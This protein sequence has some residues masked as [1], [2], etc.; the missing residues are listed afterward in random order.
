MINSRVTFIFLILSLCFVINTGKS[1]ADTSI[2]PFLVDDFESHPCDM[3]MMGLDPQ[4]GVVWEAYASSIINFK[5]DCTMA[6]SGTKSMKYTW[7]NFTLSWPRVA[8]IPLSHE[9]RIIV[10]EWDIYIPTGGG[11]YFTVNGGNNNALPAGLQVYCNSGFNEWWYRSGSDSAYKRSYVSVEFD[12]WNHVKVELNSDTLT[13]S[14]WVTTSSGAN[15]PI[16]IE[17]P[18]CHNVGLGTHLYPTWSC[19]TNTPGTNAWYDNVNCYW[20][21]EKSQGY[22]PIYELPANVIIDGV[23]SPNEWNSVKKVAQKPSGSVGNFKKSNASGANG[24]L[25]DTVV[26]VYSAND[27]NNFYIA[28]KITNAA[29]NSDTDQCSSFTAAFTWDYENLSDTTSYVFTCNSIQN[30]ADSSGVDN[31]ISYYKLESILPEPNSVNSALFSSGKIAYSV[32]NEV[33]Y[34]EMKIPFVALEDFNGINPGQKVNLQFTAKDRTPNQMSS[35]NVAGEYLPYM[36]DP[37]IFE[38][39]VDDI[40]HIVTKTMVGISFPVCGDEDHVYPISDVNFDCKV[41]F[42]DFKALAAFWLECTDVNCD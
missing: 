12:A 28:S 41:D 6:A 31:G 32:S 30:S 23:F 2:V 19:G 36:R 24:L 22:P 3:I 16:V 39:Y 5:I 14:A 11:C 17:E 13:Y 26:E 37:V 38:N 33:M 15:I 10:Y 8:P 7:Q 34:V 9:G 35:T 1:L 21:D 4:K 40:S 27:D 42:L 29:V 25:D 20:V 18:W